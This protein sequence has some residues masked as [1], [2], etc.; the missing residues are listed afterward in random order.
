[1]RVNHAQHLHGQVGI[2]ALIDKTI[3]GDRRIGLKMQSRL[4]CSAAKMLTSRQ[5]NIFD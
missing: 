2:V 3:F 5:I 4:C 1:M